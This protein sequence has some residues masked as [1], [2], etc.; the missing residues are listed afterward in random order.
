[1]LLGAGCSEST[2]PEGD[3]GGETDTTP[4]E[5]SSVTPTDQTHLEVSFNEEVDEATA[6][7]RSNYAIHLY[8]MSASPES[9]PPKSSMDYGDTL[10]VDSA[11]MLADGM[12]VR[13]SLSPPML[14]GGMYHLIADNVKD[15]SGNA[16]TGPDTLDFVGVSTPDET[17][18]EIIYRSPY[19]GETGIGIGQS[20][21]V[22][23]SEPM[24]WSSVQDAFSWKAPGDVDVSF[25]MMDIEPHIFSFTPQSPLD[26]N[27]TYSVAFAA[28][29]AMD[30]SGNYLDAASWSFTTT[31]TPD[32]TPPIVVSTTPDDGATNVALD[33]TMQI[34]FSEPIDPSSMEEGGVIIT[35]ETGDGIVTWTDGGS[36]LNFEPDDPLL[37][38]TAYYL[39]IIEGAVRDFAGNLLS[40]NY[41]VIFT[42]G[43]ALPTGGYYGTIAGDPHSTAAANPEGALSIAF[44]VNM[45]TGGGDEGPPPIGGFDVVGSDGSYEIGL[46][47]D[48]TYWPGCMMDT[49]GNGEINPDL[50]DAIGLYGIDFATL[51]GEPE[52]DS[53]IIAG[54]GTLADIDFGIYDP[55]A[56][57]GDVT[58]GGTLYSSTLYEYNYYVGLFDTLTYD[59]EN[60]DPDYGTEGQSIVYDHEFVVHE[61]NDGLVDGTYYI[62]AYMDANH[63]SDY[64][65][66][67]D[68][69][70]FYE[71]GGEMAYVTVE[72][73]EDSGDGIVV[74]LEDPEITASLNVR[75]ASWT[76]VSAAESRINPRLRA[77]IENLKRALEERQR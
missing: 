70:G 59:P 62:G 24:N 32:T 44:M 19:P 48:G 31:N 51:E 8:D 1:M 56:I 3:G 33:V 57:W 10:Y 64:D 42:T 43:A 12:S 6:Q 63:N 75:M 20:V 69:V 77:V 34:E 22:T 74:V 21:M 47:E 29:T 46:L 18:P 25:D 60:L 72:N 35:P 68:P 7:H 37:D 15:L 4:P 39:V 5:L 61:F 53:V 54:G 27:A 50:G 49:D 40:G 65:P 73:G 76:K 38:D 13:L 55:I 30:H 66:E 45:I 36:T 2:T 23:F 14:I 17:P 16:M 52:P 9:N 11:V 67:I 71:I 26:Y 58:Y 28:S 41:S